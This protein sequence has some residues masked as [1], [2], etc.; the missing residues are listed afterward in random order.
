MKTTAIRPTRY[1]CYRHNAYTRYPNSAAQRK[2]AERVLDAV[3][4]AAITIG[5]VVIVLLWLALA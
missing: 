5:M 2:T 4:A 1:S 3:L